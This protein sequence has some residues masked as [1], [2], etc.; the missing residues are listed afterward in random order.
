MGSTPLQFSKIRLTGFKSFVD[1]TELVISDGLT[2]VVGP[3]GCGKSN[4]LEALRWVMGENRPTAMRGGGMEDVIFAG[5]ASRPA[6]NYAEVLLTLDNS[7]R[8]APAA[9]NDADNLEVVRRI[10]RDAG[11]AYKTNGKEAR[12]RDVQMLFADAS[13]GA[14]SPAL[15]RQGQISELIN[16]KPKSRR[17]V[18]EEAAGIS[19]LYQRRH[20]AELKLNGAET[21][22]AR[23][24]DVVEQLDA[25]LNTL[26]RQARQAA[27]YRSILDELR[28][29]EGLLLYR[30]WR[31]ADLALAAAI[32]QL[33]AATKLAASGQG[34][35][36]QAAKL[37]MDLEGKV[38]PLREEE[39]IA[40]AIVQRL[41][42][43]R[44]ALGDQENRAR[45]TIETLRGRIDQL[46]KDIDRESGLNRDAEETIKRLDWEFE[47]IVKASDG[48]DGRI[49]A[50]GTQAHDAAS[51]MQEKEADLDRHN[52]DVA[53]LSAR[54]QSSHRMLSDARQVMGKRSEQ[55]QAAAASVTAAKAGLSEAEQRLAEASTTFGVAQEAA[56]RAENTLADV[57]VRRSDEQSKDSEARAALS[58]ADGEANALNAEVGALERVIARDQSGGAQ[59]IDEVRAA[60]GYE[61]ALG[62]ALADDLKAPV[63]AADGISGWAQMPSYSGVA[64]LPSGVDALGVHVT[65]PD[66]LARRLGQI[67]VVA[68]ADGARLQ[69]DLQ[70]GQR[71]VS[72]E[73]DLWRWDGFRAGG[74]DAP[75]AAAL[76]LQQVN[77]LEELREAHGVAADAASAARATFDTVHAALQATIAA[78]QEA[79]RARKVAD[80]TA[81]TATRA[82]SRA[83]AD[84]DMLSGKVETQSLAEARHREETLA[85]FATVKEA[86]MAVRE[87]G[88]LNAARE[89]AEALK[90]AVEA[91]RMTMLTKRSLY[92]EQRRDGEARTK[93]RQEITKEVSGWRHRLETAEAR[94]AELA[95]RK[96]T[97]EAELKDATAAPEEIAAKREELGR[98]IEKAEGR[99]KA[100]SDGLAVAE[101]NLRQAE[102]GERDAERAASEAREARARADAVADSARVQM[103]AA[104]DRIREELECSPEKLLESL[105]ADPED[106][107]PVQVIENDVA[108]LRR[109]RDALGAVNLRAEEDSKEVAEERDALVT[110]KSDLEEAI[111]ALRTGIASLNKEGRER[112]LAAFDE[113]NANFSLLFKHLFGGGDANL[114]LVESDDPLEAGL[115]I[116]CQPPGK[117][118]STLSL[119]SGGEQTLTALSLI[120]AVFLANPSPICVL[121][122][123]DAPLDDANVTRFCDLLDEMTRRTNTRFLI[124][125]HHAVTMS[126]MDRLFGV[127]MAELGVSQLVSVDLRQAE[128]M[129][130]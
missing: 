1:P 49:E 68:R 58:E 60:K 103:E 118:L 41:R 39:A 8:L 115:E 111:K 14:H 86:E 37:R 90:V 91:A 122:E 92:D 24:D 34:G 105:Q 127:T 38:P 124:I 63:V 128:R 130:G 11:S 4:L 16:A 116:M 55:S 57:E 114:V 129:V 51:V 2:G 56:L 121:D 113:V 94:I 126:R 59:V 117:K 104:G 83:E 65:A 84:R 82:M 76:R 10:T 108:R 96:E 71:L 110:E 85:A 20:E 89:T 69:A 26:A 33:T 32:D 120:F 30:R 72:L 9:F 22:L 112:L 43:E 5:A 12:A 54:H 3:N 109:Q 62:A 18:L 98:E 19:G 44:D 23:V 123:V 101:T 66:V 74:D 70:P 107:P 67:G 45:A 102:Q 77:R 36:A 27:R 80:E 47:A 79:R 95:A 61:A 93:R 17:R 119:L 35:A 99:L 29:S 64:A 78:D 53:R 50:A 106:M 28:Q 97:S 21:N 88:D 48:Q 13:T 25:Q 87:L 7:D 125:T 15:V 42:V 73:G 100:A 6:R 31:E 75:S 40:G 81:T 46:G 52:E